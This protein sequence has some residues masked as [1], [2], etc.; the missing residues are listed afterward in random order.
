MSDQRFAHLRDRWG[1]SPLLF[2]LDTFQVAAPKH[3]A[4]V[5]QSGLRGQLVLREG[6]DL[7]EQVEPAP[8]TRALFQAMQRH[9]SYP[10]QWCYDPP[11]WT[12]ERWLDAAAVARTRALIDQQ[13]AAVHEYALRVTGLQPVF[14]LYY[15]D[16]TVESQRRFICAA[17]GPEKQPFTDR[18]LIDPAMFGKTFAAIREQHLTA[19]SL[20][21]R[22][23]PVLWIGPAMKLRFS[24]DQQSPDTG[25]RVFTDLNGEFL[26]SDWCQRDGMEQKAKGNGIDLQLRRYTL[27]S[28]II[29]P[30]LDRVGTNFTATHQR[31]VVRLNQKPTPAQSLEKRLEWHYRKPLWKITDMGEAHDR[32]INMGDNES[33]PVRF[34]WTL[35]DPA[36]AWLNAPLDLCWVQG[37]MAVMSEQGRWVR[38]HDCLRFLTI[39]TTR[40]DRPAPPAAFVPPDGITLPPEVLEAAAQHFAA[41]RVEVPVPAVATLPPYTQS[42]ICG[43]CFLTIVNGTVE[44]HQRC[45]DPEHAGCALRTAQVDPQP[46]LGDQVSVPQWPITRRLKVHQSDN[47]V[48]TVTHPCCSSKTLDGVVLP[49]NT[50][51]S[52]CQHFE[53]EIPSA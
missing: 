37:S 45:Y 4:F 6:N 43:S 20:G 46:L 14:L 33:I 47:E 15:S 19:T 21:T 41:H 1:G 16:G 38:A 10:N 42:A 30:Y 8:M 48:V 7:I 13:F 23:R 25:V 40:V 27:A 12:T 34:R 36:L 17:H 24:I 2:D 44:G 28:W 39:D 29:G 35:R 26:C 31:K 50:V 18:D 51:C 9:T 32:L 49:G 52:K 53:L 11:H 5:G 3:D 22:Y